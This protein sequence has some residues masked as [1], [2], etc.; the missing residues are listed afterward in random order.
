MRKSLILLAMALA[1]VIIANRNVCAASDIQCSSN[2]EVEQNAYGQN[3]YKTSVNI[4]GLDKNIAFDRIYNFF[5]K[6]GLQISGSDRKAGVISAINPVMHSKKT[7]PFNVVIEAD[8]SGC[9][10]AL[11]YV[12][13]PGMTANPRD[14]VYY[15]CQVIGAASGIH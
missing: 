11:T 9:Q 7:T 3:K 6:D 4:A 13:E 2:F 14:V 5:G 10:I 15:F 12:T 8:N 1:S